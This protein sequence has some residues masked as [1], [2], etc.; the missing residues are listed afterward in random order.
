M[1]LCMYQCLCLEVFQPG[2]PVSLL[3]VANVVLSQFED[4]FSGL[5][6]LVLLPAQLLELLNAGEQGLVGKTQE[7][8]ETWSPHMPHN[9]EAQ[10]T[11][12]HRA[13]AEG[14]VSGPSTHV[15]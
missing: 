14:R 10:S 11:S 7:T 13:T 1:S 6:E 4:E 12:T 15:E 5:E 3:Q 9:H 2:V 8:A